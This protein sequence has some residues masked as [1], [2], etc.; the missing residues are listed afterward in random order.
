MADYRAVAEN[1]PCEPGTLCSPRKQ[2][3]CH[4]IIQSHQKDLGG[5]ETPTD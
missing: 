1:V 2:E 3:S 5:K 4:R